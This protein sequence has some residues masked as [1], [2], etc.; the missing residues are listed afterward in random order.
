M[1]E[2]M[3]KINQELGLLK[4]TLIKV[5]E[6][7]NKNLIIYQS[8]NEREKEIE[9]RVKII[10]DFMRIRLDMCVLTPS[11]SRELFK[12]KAGFKFDLFNCSEGPCPHNE[13]K[14]QNC[15]KLN[16]QSEFEKKIKTQHA[17]SIQE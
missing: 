8:M 7:F 14:N 10:K 11:L 16:I 15:H 4:V 12:D 6:Y 1:I 3:T 2:S 13:W 9:E 5:E 17:R